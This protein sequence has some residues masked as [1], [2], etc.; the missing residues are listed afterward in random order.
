MDREDMDRLWTLLSTVWSRAPQIGDRK[1]RQAWTLALEPFSYGQIR[2]AAAEYIR[3]NKFFPD[4]CD[5]TALVKAEKTEPETPRDSYRALER[6]AEEIRSEYHRRGVPSPG[7]A[8]RDG[9]G[10][11][12]WMMKWGGKE[13]VG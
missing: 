10:Y 5:I 6:H 3:N 4:I 8:L 11:S 1:L 9:F 2:S 12:K 7:E 13:H